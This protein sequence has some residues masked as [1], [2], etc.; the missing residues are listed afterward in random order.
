MYIIT[1]Y[2]MTIIHIFNK[3]YNLKIIHFNT[4]IYRLYYLPFNNDY[5][6]YTYRRE[7]ES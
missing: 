5:V 6:I 1:I 2:S 7:Y 3:L 4:N